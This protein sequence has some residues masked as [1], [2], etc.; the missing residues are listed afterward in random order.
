M[1]LLSRRLPR[2]SVPLPNA[3]GFGQHDCGRWPFSW[4]PVRAATGIKL[5]RGLSKSCHRDVSSG[6]AAVTR[7]RP[8]RR[9]VV[10]Q[11]SKR[12]VE[13]TVIQALLVATTLTVSWTVWR[14]QG[15][16]SSVLALSCKLTHSSMAR[17]ELTATIRE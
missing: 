15:I 12:P 8:H 2:P 4:L 17:S 6:L 1:L 10:E 14:A 11:P 7:R 5:S 3:V 9:E 16:K 13:G